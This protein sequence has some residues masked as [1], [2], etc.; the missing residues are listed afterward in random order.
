MF[1]ASVLGVSDNSSFLHRKTKIAPDELFYTNNHSL[2]Q[3]Y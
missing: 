1:D 3:K 2:N